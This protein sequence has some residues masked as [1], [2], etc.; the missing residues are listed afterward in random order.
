[1]MVRWQPTLSTAFNWWLL[2]FLLV[3]YLKAIWP[4][5]IFST[6]RRTLCG[7][8]PD[9]G[10]GRYFGIW[11]F[12]GIQWVHLVFERKT[13]R[14]GAYAW[15]SA[16]LK[17]WVVLNITSLHSDDSMSNATRHSCPQSP[18][19]NTRGKFSMSG[20]WARIA[21]LLPAHPLP[22]LRT[23]EACPNIW[24]ITTSSAS[25]CLLSPWIW[26][27][28]PS[29]ATVDGQIVGSRGKWWENP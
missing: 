17:S 18:R 15:I 5:F 27:Y 23:E 1:M 29:F 10:G 16:N 12:A 6:R 11:P 20:P 3:P 19:S 26:N 22:I 28:A 13:F 9:E 8:M 2:A 25:H 24:S 4:S 7:H 21:L 14:N